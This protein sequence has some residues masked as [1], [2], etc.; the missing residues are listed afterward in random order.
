MKLGIVYSQPKDTGTG[1]HWG[2]QLIY[3]VNFLKVRDSLLARSLAVIAAS[4]A[5]V[6]AELK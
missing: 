1:R 4:D 5:R 3:A 2:T 6:L